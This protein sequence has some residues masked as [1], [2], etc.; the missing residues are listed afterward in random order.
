M[1]LKCCLHSSAFFP[2]NKH[3]L[4]SW[5]DI[6]IVVLADIGGRARFQGHCKVYCIGRRLHR[7]SSE[8]KLPVEVICIKRHRWCSLSLTWSFRSGKYDVHVNPFVLIHADITLTTSTNV[9]EWLVTVDYRLHFFFA[10]LS[11]WILVTETLLKAAMNVQ[12]TSRNGCII[13]FY[14]IILFTDSFICL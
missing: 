7:G 10:C 13:L 14:R 2:L 9:P 8:S 1:T 12:R 4:S 5:C 11:R 3:Y 6:L